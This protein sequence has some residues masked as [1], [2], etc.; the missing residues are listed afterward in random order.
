MSSFPESL[1][2]FSLDGTKQ[3]WPES[4]ALLGMQHACNEDRDSS[5]R[6]LFTGHP[7]ASCTEPWDG[8][9]GDGSHRLSTSLPRKYF[10][11]QLFLEWVSLSVQERLDY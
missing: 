3:Q 9:E 5:P 10:W 2:S 6:M 1:K 8:V 7:Q 11:G 4:T